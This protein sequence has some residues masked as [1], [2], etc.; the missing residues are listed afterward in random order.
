[1]KEY[2]IW[3]KKQVKFCIFFC[4]I[5]K[6]CTILLPWKKVKYNYEKYTLLIE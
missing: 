4:V 1:M 2:V 6:I 5:V 3:T